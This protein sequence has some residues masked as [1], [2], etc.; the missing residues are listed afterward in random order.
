[1]L[2]IQ[3]WCYACLYKMPLILS[4]I[5]F[6]IKCKSS[7]LV[8]FIFLITKLKKI[9]I[10]SKIK[11]EKRKHKIFLS[12]KIISNDW[13]SSSAYFFYNLLKKLPNNFRYLEIGSYQG[14][15][16]L[17]VANNFQESTVIC[18]DPWLAYEELKFQDMN[19][20]EKIFD[21]NISKFN[22]INKVKSTSDDFFIKNQ[23]MFDFIYI[24]GY[25][26]FDY[27]L[28]DCNNAWKFLKKEGVLV[29]DDYIWSYYEDWLDNPCYAINEFIKKNNG[30]LKVLLVTNSQI[31][32]KKL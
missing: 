4:K 11:Q 32:I 24:D 13:F 19:A 16:A 21:L 8:I 2:P 1:M 29:C 14:N 28:R 20:I 10:K 27:V 26:K 17:Y 30:K 7:I 15:S 18:V 5:F 23:T 3:L 22:N 12:D 6:L 31:F 25:H 9:F